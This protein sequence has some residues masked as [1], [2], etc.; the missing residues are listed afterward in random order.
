LNQIWTDAGREGKP[1]VVVLVTSK[2]EPGQ[3]E[4][5]AEAGVDECMFGLPD[6]SEEETKAFIAKMGAALNS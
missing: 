4:R 3:V 1:R 2:L 6:K 5:W